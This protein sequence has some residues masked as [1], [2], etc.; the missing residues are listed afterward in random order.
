VE[1]FFG[2]FEWM[3]AGRFFTGISV[4]KVEGCAQ[5]P[6]SVCGN[7]QSACAAPTY[8][9]YP[10]RLMSFCKCPAIRN[11]LAPAGAGNF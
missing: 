11:F 2:Q 1:H 3:A 6:T 8:S 4:K 7:E 5:W 9:N 10:P